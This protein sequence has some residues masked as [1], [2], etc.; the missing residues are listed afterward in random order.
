MLETKLK[1]ILLRHT[2]NPEETVAMA[3][4]LCYSPSDIESLKEKI[5]YFLTHDEDREKIR[6]AGYEFT[7]KNY[8][9]TKRVEEMLR[10]LKVEGLIK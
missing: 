9:Y 7:H 4:K 5:D 3:A 2:P 10:V 8:T 6:K 1:V